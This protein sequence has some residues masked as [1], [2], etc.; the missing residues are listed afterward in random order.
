M[1]IENIQLF[2]ERLL[3]ERVKLTQQEEMVAWVLTGIFRISIEEIYK[4]G[5]FYVKYWQE[6][7]SFLLIRPFFCTFSLLLSDF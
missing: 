4:L 5:I 1:I 6:H 3:D 2:Q 7:I